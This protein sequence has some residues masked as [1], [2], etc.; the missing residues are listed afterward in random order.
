MKKIPSQAIDHS[1]SVDYEYFLG[2]VFVNEATIKLLRLLVVLDFALERTDW[3]SGGF[4]VVVCWPPASNAP[5]ELP[6][7]LFVL[8][9]RGDFVYLE[10]FKVFLRN[11][12]VV[13]YLGILLC[14][15]ILHHDLVHDQHQRVRAHCLDSIP[16]S[17]K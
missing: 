1:F 17:L 5:P 14:Y 10:V 11:H 12:P 8:V 2:F 4:A 3:H 15:C 16:I 13:G 9:L 6:I 7:D